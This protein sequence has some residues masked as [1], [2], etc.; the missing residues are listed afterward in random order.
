MEIKEKAQEPYY[1]DG[2]YGWVIVG[3]IMLINVSLL[4]LVPCFGLIFGQEFNEWGVTS[5]QTSFLLHLH[6][7]LY[8][9]FGFFTSPVLKR[10][11]MKPVALF[12]AALM[13]L[14]IL[15]SSFATS[16]IHLIGS[17]SVLIGLGQG[18]VMPATYLGTY[19]YFK[20]RLTIAVS[21][22]ITSASLSPIVIPK[23]CDVMLSLV[24]RKYTVLLLFGV[25]LFSFIGCL[26]LKPVRRKDARSEEM[27]E[28]KGALSTTTQQEAT[29]FFLQDDQ[30]DPVYNDATVSKKSKTAVPIG[31]KLFDIFDLQLL[32]N[33]PLV[34][35]IVGLG[36]SFAAEL[37]IILMLQFMLG[38]LSLF[39]RSEIATAASIQSAADIV[40][41]LVVPM[42]VHYFKVHAKLTYASALV[43]AILART[44]LSTWPT[45]KLVVYVVVTAIGLTKG[46]R[47]VFQSVLLPNYVDLDKITA[48]NGINML[49]TGIVSLIV[50]PLIGLVRDT[51]GS[52]IYALHSASLLS[53]LCVVM[54]IIEY[55]FWERNNSAQVLD[56]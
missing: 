37:N 35:M 21:L 15:L 14:G 5:T 1:P 23:V 48:A 30:K 40:G 53:A 29:T 9:S 49:F 31:L 12:G 34:I 38:K 10:Y 42:C 46:T 22:T 13:C 47:A 32:H 55:F 8:C 6:S 11:G 51:S 17:T 43:V 56:K 16:Y 54:W 45:Q 7:S 18:I 25:S 19:I 28:V 2:G 4:T 39:N 33:T 24:G 52:I 44:A 3:A 20:K 41:R 50:G 36:V 26:L 27:M